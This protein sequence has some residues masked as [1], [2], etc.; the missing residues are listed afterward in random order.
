MDNIKESIEIAIN[1]NI[2]IDIRQINDSKYTE[3]ACLT[4]MLQIFG[5][6]IWILTQED[7]F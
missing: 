7:N 1:A 3:V 6:F 4:N 2:N 5:G